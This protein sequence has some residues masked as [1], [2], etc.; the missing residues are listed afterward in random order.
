MLKLEEKLDKTPFRTAASMTD[1]A[2][3]AKSLPSRHPAPATVQSASMKLQKAPRILQRAPNWQND[4]E[5]VQS[6]PVNLQAVPTTV[7][8]VIDNVRG[9]ER[10]ETQ[11]L[12]LWNATPTNKRQVKY[13][14][15]V[16]GV[17]D[18]SGYATAEHRNDQTVEMEVD[19]TNDLRS[20]SAPNF[21]TGS[22][23]IH[24]MNEAMDKDTFSDIDWKFLNGLVDKR[25]STDQVTQRMDSTLPLSSEQAQHQV[26]LKGPVSKKEPMPGTSASAIKLNVD[27]NMDSSVNSSTALQEPDSDPT[28]SNP[29]TG[30][31]YYNRF[32]FHIR[33]LGTE[34]VQLMH[35]KGAVN[36]GLVPMAY[37]INQLDWFLYYHLRTMDSSINQSGILPSSNAQHFSAV[38]GG[39]TGENQIDPTK[40]P[41]T[42]SNLVTVEDYYR[43]FQTHYQGMYRDLKEMIE[44]RGFD[45]S[46]LQH[47]LQSLNMLNWIMQY[48]LGISFTGEDA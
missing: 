19:H 48:H 12:N 16:G 17:G 22:P 38:A 26:I 43:S 23:L 45:D 3:T 6:V 24:L 15:G 36:P 44:G 1:D 34:Y 46:A 35:E 2:K 18:A 40:K 41:D 13:S 14:P 20:E 33:A 7:Q 11:A 9:L 32:Q 10:T 29:V 21:S 4:P 37:V 47:L 28:T 25:K 5:T 31:E 30:L 8:S 27:K 42:P 39:N